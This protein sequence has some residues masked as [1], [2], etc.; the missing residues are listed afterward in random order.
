MIILDLSPQVETQIVQI[1]K[2]QNMS[3]SDCLVSMAE[4]LVDEQQPQP[5]LAPQEEIG[6]DEFFELTGIRSL[7]S[8]AN[9]QPVTNDY[10]NELRGEHG[11]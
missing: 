10:I 11:I 1:A 2:Q 9:A 5:F 6:D 3:A 4:K 7:P 8:S